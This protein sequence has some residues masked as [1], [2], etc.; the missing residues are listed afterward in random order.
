[1]TNF[2]SE[3][4]FTQAVRKAARQFGWHE[5]HTYS[6]LKSTPGFPDLV[7]V[8]S[9]QM[10]IFAELKMPKGKLTPAQ[11]DW[12][13]VLRKNLTVRYFVWRPADWDRILEILQQ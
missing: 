6:S 10:V 4:H 9:D 13:N 11:Q 8:K 3:K 1:M 7:L 12:G 5:Y 2:K